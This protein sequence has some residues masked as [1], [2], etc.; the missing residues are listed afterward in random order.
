MSALEIEDVLRIHDAIDQVAVVGITDEQW[1][2]RVAAAVVLERDWALTL[3][4][5]RDWGKQQLAPYKVP[6]LLLIVDALP[7]NVLG[8]VTKHRVV[9]MFEAAAR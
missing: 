4:E 9:E 8:K 5:L 1:G 2:Q 6:S 3:E 7:R